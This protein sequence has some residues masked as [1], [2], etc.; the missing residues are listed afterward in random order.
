[1]GKSNQFTFEIML[2]A[3]KSN[4]A[5]YDGKFWLGVKSTN[6]YCLPSCKARFP[7][8]KN[9]LFFLKREE[10]VKNGFRGCKRCKSEFYPFVEPLWL[11]SIKQYMKRNLNRKITE[12][13]LIEIA[14]VDITTIRRYFKFHQKISLLAYHRK[15]RMSHAKKLLEKGTDVKSVY[16][17]VGYQSKEGFIHAFKQEFGYL[18]EVY[19]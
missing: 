3:A 1:M 7:L 2:N 18:P 12:I 17:L 11:E 13:E 16:K 4:D 9:L 8:E 10:A 15:L 19:Q 14:D 6:I 5:F